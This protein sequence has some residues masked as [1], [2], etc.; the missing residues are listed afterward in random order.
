MGKR[1]FKVEFRET[2]KVCGRPLDS[3]KRQRTFC[4]E[5]CRNKNEYQKN[6]VRQAEYQR[7]RAD[8]LAEFPGKDKK[9]C[10]ICGRWYVQVGTH[11]VQKHKITA[12]E[13]RQMFDLP[14]KRGI[15]SA[16]YRK[17]KRDAVFENGTVNNLSTEKAKSNRFKKNDPRAAANS[18]WKGRAGN[19]GYQSNEYY[20]A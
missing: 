9:K 10:M 4:S 2:C 19:K 14:L 20:G 12:R 7:L 5:K 13:Y 6:K 17:V 1:A 8:K 18:G 16:G 11:V 3:T 15:T